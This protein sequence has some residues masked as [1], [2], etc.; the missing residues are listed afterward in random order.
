MTQFRDFI[1]IVAQSHEK[2]YRQSL[3]M[4]CGNIS[5]MVIHLSEIMTAVPCPIEPWVQDKMS[6]SFEEVSSVW[7]GLM[8]HE[9][10]V[11]E[12]CDDVHMFVSNI[13]STV[14]YLHDITTCLRTGEATIDPWMLDK[15]ARASENIATVWGYIV[16]YQ[17][18]DEVADQDVEWDALD[19]AAHKHEALDKALW[20]RAKAEA[21]KKFDV[22]PSA[23]A[24]GWAVKWYKE[25][26]GKWKTVEGEVIEDI[27]IA[28]KKTER[29]VH[30][31]KPKL[32][33]ADVME[34]LAHWFNQHW[35]DISRTDKNGKHPACG[36][37]AGSGERG[38]DGQ[39]AYPKCRP[40]VSAAHMSDKEKK[41][42]IRRKR[43]VENGPEGDR[44]S[45]NWVKTKKY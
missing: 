11:T 38:K 42:A 14:K 2:S 34:D 12:D 26:G 35:V 39:R 37:S 25:R 19:E 29:D 7:R 20:G 16:E 45:P 21:K 18:E 33:S 8:G 9:M 17:G 4:M 15:M 43:D 5:S 27:L 13:R 1:N 22:Y 30:S 10:V 44:K 40:A 6:R 3:G 41:S 23:Y 36:A 24:N 32:E 31:K 28:K